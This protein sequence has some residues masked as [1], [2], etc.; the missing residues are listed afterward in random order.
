[1]TV[2]PFPCRVSSSRYLKTILKFDHVPEISPEQD[3]F[4]LKFIYYTV[5]M[6]ETKL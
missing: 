2:T 3:Y 4:A 1:M 5:F 6:E